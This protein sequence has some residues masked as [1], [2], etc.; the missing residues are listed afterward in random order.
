MMFISGYRVSQELP[1]FFPP[2]FCKIRGGST[3]NEN[4]SATEQQQPVR[5][6]NERTRRVRLLETG[7]TIPACVASTLHRAPTVAA[8]TFIAAAT[9][10]DA[11]TAAAA[12]AVTQTWRQREVAS[13]PAGAADL[14]LRTHI[15]R[16]PRDVSPTGTPTGKGCSAAVT[17][18]SPWGAAPVPL[19]WK[20]MYG[21]GLPVCHVTILDTPPA[22]R[23]WALGSL[24][25][26]W[27][28]ERHRRSEDG[29]VGPWEP[30]LCEL[31]Y[32]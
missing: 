22:L 3:E 30:A 16:L 21:N 10:M 32:G 4:R 18:R 20:S 26:W 13:P 23:R 7:P 6:R 17:E 29:A 27:R 15:W 31:V 25:E 5:R 28:K 11:A 12:T 2:R 24:V 8:T 19:A 9:P 14:C 1:P